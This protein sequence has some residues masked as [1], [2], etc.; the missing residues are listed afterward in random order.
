MLG[1]VVGIGSTAQIGAAVICVG[2]DSHVNVESSL[3]TCCIVYASHDEGVH[4]GQA[5]TSPGCSDCMDVPLRVPPFKSKKPQLSTPRINAE[6]RT[7]AL[8]CGGGWRNDLLVPA[9]PMD[10]RWQ[11][12]SPLSS[13][14]LLT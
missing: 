11:S 7:A 8:I 6:G 13:V 9:D 4:S 12:L 5:P 14:V 10:Q 2:F 3:C 1:A